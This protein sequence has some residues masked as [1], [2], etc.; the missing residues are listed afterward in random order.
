M[1]YQNL[2]DTMHNLY[3]WGCLESEAFEIINAVKKDTQ[4]QADNAERKYT[5]IEIANA[6]HSG[7]SRKFNDV[8][9][10]FTTLNKQ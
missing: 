5:E 7:Q 1:N 6:F 8:D 10:F 9:D 3:G 4:C 2:F